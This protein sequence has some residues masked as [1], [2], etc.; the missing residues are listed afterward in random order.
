MIPIVKHDS[1]RTDCR[2]CFQTALEALTETF[3]LWIDNDNLRH[4]DETDT[5]TEMS[6]RVA[7]LLEECEK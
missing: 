5:N 7:R 6:V 2:Y 3:V 1:N 4:I